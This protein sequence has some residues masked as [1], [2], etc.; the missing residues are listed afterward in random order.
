MKISIITLKYSIIIS[1]FYFISPIYVD[2]FYDEFTIAG[3]LA[4]GE[5][6]NNYYD[7]FYRSF[8]FSIYFIPLFYISIYYLLELLKDNNSTLTNKN[9]KKSS[10][11][12]NILIIFVMALYF[13]FF[14]F[15]LGITGVET[16]TEFHLSGI[17]H[18][19]RSYIFL[20]VIVL[21]L[22]TKNPS[23][24]LLVLYSLIAGFTASSRFVA[25][26]PLVFYLIF[27]F[28]N[29][30][31][32]SKKKVFI[33][34]LAIITIFMLITLSRVWV[35]SEDNFVEIELNIDVIKSILNQLFLRSGLGRDVILSEEI[36][37]TRNCDQY[38][39]FFITGTSCDYPPLDFYGF[40]L[41]D[42]KWYTN[43]P[44][45]ASFYILPGNIFIQ[46]LLYLFFMILVIISGNL[47]IYNSK[48]SAL[49]KKLSILSW[50]LSL[51]F[52][53]IGPLLFFHY[54]TILVFLNV[55]IRKVKL[56][57]INYKKGL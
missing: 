53:Y 28:F 51:V 36:L 15:R 11:P 12:Y 4:I 34:F 31:Y 25:I 24:T 56:F 21:Y 33:I 27:L 45:L 13:V 48:T 6:D 49:I 39:K 19:F 44:T 30:N 14:Y 2:M 43:A 40:V 9:Y 20:L 23:L 37:N 29:S 18:Y 26:M 8:K 5:Y 1:L 50:A 16:P 52:L 38:I 42:N 41:P 3:W 32:F 54:L 55:F 46:I 17:V 47:H 10:F 57:I 35:F 7:G 22:N